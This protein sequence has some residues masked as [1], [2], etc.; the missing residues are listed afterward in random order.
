MLAATHS[1]PQLIVDSH[2]AGAARDAFWLVGGRLVDWGGVSD[3]D[4]LVARTRAALTRASRRGE[5]GAHVPPGEID[6]VRILAAHLTS[7]PEL[8][9]LGLDPAPDDAALAGFA[10]ELGLGSAEREL[11]D[12]RAH[13]VRSHGHLGAG[14]RLT[15]HERERERSEPR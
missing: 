9:R 15:S 2:P 12:R 6:E 11:D 13:A 7:H 14:R 4:E 8:P 1:Q 3:I 5:L 10:R